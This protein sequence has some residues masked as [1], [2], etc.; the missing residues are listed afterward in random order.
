[1]MILFAAVA[2][3][4]TQEQIGSGAAGDLNEL[5]VGLVALLALSKLVNYN[6]VVYLVAAD[7]FGAV[8]EVVKVD[9]LF[10]RAGHE[11]EGWA[12]GLADVHERVAP[13][14]ETLAVPVAGPPHHH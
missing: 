13:V 12:V 4:V 7:D 8:G 11:L 3:A 6:F 10:D 14:V 5:A 2:V 9:A 1:M